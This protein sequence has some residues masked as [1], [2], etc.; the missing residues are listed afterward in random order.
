MLLKPGPGGYREQDGAQVSVPRLTPQLCTPRPV[1]SG[2][3]GRREEDPRCPGASAR[4]GPVGGGDAVPICHQ[5]G[6]SRLDRNHCKR[7][8]RIEEFNPKRS[9]RRGGGQEGCRR[10]V[11]AFGRSRVWGS[12]ARGRVGP[13][14]QAAPLTPRVAFQVHPFQR[15]TLQVPGVREGLLP[16]QDPGGP[17]NPT[18]AGE[19]G[20]P[21]T[22]PRVGPRR[23]PAP[24]G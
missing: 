7:F 20:A 13:A 8:E 9:L 17:Q 18:H 12:G 14:L 24:A 4:S 21:R 10:G 11:R 23:G 15:E 16:V 3:R 2:A 6:P 19:S 22:P 1:R 5:R